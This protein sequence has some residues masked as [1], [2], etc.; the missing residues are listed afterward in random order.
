MAAELGVE[1][2]RLIS[3]IDLNPRLRDLGLG[4]LLDGAPIKREAW[5]TREFGTSPFQEAARELRLGTPVV[6]TQRD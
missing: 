1:P 2:A 5:E 6:Y 4:P 3:A